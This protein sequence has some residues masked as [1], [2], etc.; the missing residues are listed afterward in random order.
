MVKK[1]NCVL[2]DSWEADWESGRGDLKHWRCPV[3]G[4]FT[5]TF[6]CQVN[7]S[8]SDEQLKPFLSAATRQAYEERGPLTL[9]TD[10]CQSHA[11]AHRWTSVNSKAR[12]ILEFISRRS[13][14]FGQAVQVAPVTDYP[15]FD[16]V[17][18][19][20]CWALIGHLSDQRLLT[21]SSDQK[22]YTLT[23]AGW[24]YLAPTSGGGVPGRCFVAMSFHES[25]NSAYGEAIK[26]AILECGY[27]PVCMKEVLT[28]DKICDRILAEIRRAQFVVADFTLQRGGVY[29]EAGFAK[30]LGKEVFWMCRE[31]DFDHVH[32]DTNHYGHIKWTNPEDLR[33]QLGERILGE[34]G[35]G[36]YRSSS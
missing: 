18:H 29:F 11:E 1:S 16:A 31:D 12:K 20:E 34:L 28:N 33:K 22:N 2:C 23:M 14:A 19:Q 17:S 7:V 35:M 21:M 10:N 3:C 27:E 5:I 24:E 30:A 9:T 26:P 25:L 36:P 32:F 13:S 8:N 6:E 4:H 15:L